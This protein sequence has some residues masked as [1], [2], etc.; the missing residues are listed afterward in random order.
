MNYTV[1]ISP[2]KDRPP[3]PECRHINDGEYVYRDQRGREL[4]TKQR[5]LHDPCECGRGK[6]F[7]YRWKPPYKPWL[8]RRG[9]QQSLYEKPPDADWYLYRLDVIY[10]LIARS[11]SEPIYWC[12]GEKDADA[13]ADLSVASTTH[14]QGAGKATLQQ[15]SWLKRARRVVLVADLDDAG[16]YDAARRHDL[17]L[18]AG[19]KGEI[20]I[21]RA[22]E[23]NDAADHLAAGYRLDQF[24]P[25]DLSL[26][27]RAARRFKSD[28]KKNQ[29]RYIGDDNA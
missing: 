14:H 9:Y 21:V 8:T 18:E 27:E 15:A 5:Y 10:P 3:K 6:S 29:T 28:L 20:S 24:V 13:L 22:Q 1:P 12:E 25:A 11:E 26:L 23:G 7:G 2:R 17:L 16:A 4:F 19:C